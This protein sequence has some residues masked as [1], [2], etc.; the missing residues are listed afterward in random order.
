MNMAKKSCEDYSKL[1]WTEKTKIELDTK[2]K[3]K[4]L[5]SVLDSRKNDFTINFPTAIELAFALGNGALVEYKDNGETII[6]YVDGDLIMPYK[7]TNSYIYGLITISRFTEII[8]EEECYYTHLTYH[9]F[10][11]Q[12]YTKVNE[13]Y[14]SDD[15]SELGKLEDFKQKF[16][17]VQDFFSIN[18]K[19]PHFQVFGPNL[20][21]NYDFNTPLKI[22]IYS[23]H[24]DKLESIDEKYDSFRREFRAGR[25]RI[26]VN[27]KALKAKVDVDEE[28][29]ETRT[30]KYFDETDDT[31]V[32]IQ[33]TDMKDQPVKEIDMTIRYKEHIESINA[34]LNWYSSHI[35]LGS[36][37]YKFDGVSVK[38]A[39]E[40]M[41]EDSEAFRSKEHHQLVIH[42]AIYDMVAAICEL[43]G[44]DYKDITITADDSVIEDTDTK[45]MRSMQEVSQGLKSK[46]RYMTDDK[47][48]SEKEAE[49]ELLQIEK[50]RHSDFSIDDVEE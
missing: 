22:G 12:V 42:N 13:L 27:P 35:G 25:K 17:N 9:E 24:F 3:T 46:K 2:E 41:S 28:T 40:V 10:D 31:Y 29:G 20:A 30:V 37:Y 36:N 50:E 33:G 11:G 45:Q 18:T 6:D 34:E 14:L 32:A 4:R 39:K 5:W 16:P 23:N 43:E 44:I 21:N 48:M 8:N 19:T 15:K 47:G 1:L 7:F 26:V 49:E 38:T